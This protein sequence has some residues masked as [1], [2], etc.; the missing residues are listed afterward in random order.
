LREVLVADRNNLTAWELLFNVAHDNEERSF[1][2][3]A[4]LTLRPDH[5][6]ARQKLAEEPQAG[7]GKEDELSSLLVNYGRHRQR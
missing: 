6:W 4:I 5:P 7:Q 3:K 1:C 2:L